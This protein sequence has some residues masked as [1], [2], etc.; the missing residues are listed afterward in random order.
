M[1][2]NTVFYV[3]LP[4]LTETLNSSYNLVKQRIE[5]NP[6]LSA[7]MNKQQAKEDRPFGF[8]DKAFARL[9]E[10]GSHLGEEITM[11][12]ELNPQGSPEEPLFVADLRNADGLRA[13]ID[14]LGNAPVQIVDDPATA[15]AGPGRDLYLWLNG[16]LLAASPKLENL[17]KF[18]VSLK[19]ESSFKSTSF[20]ARI[21]DRYR[22]GTSVIVAGDLE[23][24]TPNIA[25]KDKKAN[26]ASEQLGFTNFKHLIA[27]IKDGSGKAQNSAELTFSEANKGIAAWLAQ[28]A[29]M[30]SLNYISADANVIGAVVIKDPTAMADNLINAL[31]SVEPKFG[32]E[33]A[34]FEA[35]HGLSIRNDIAAP[36]GGEFAF[37][38]DGPLVPIPS[39]KIVVEVYDQARMQQTFERIV[40]EL[41]RLSQQ[42][43]KKGFT[44]DKSEESGQ[45][46]YTIK[47][48]DFPVEVNYAFSSGYVV[49]APSKALITRALQYRNS[50]NTIMRS[51]RFIASLPEDKQA[52]FSAMFY[53]NLAPVVNPIARSLGNINGKMR[54]GEIGAIASLA[55]DAPSLAYAYSY[56]DR[57]TLSVNT[58][59][60]ALNIGDLLSVPGSFAMQG[61]LKGAMKQ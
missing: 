59:K 13:A 21:A 18:A 15:Q 52:N 46:F 42:A 34:K 24:I 10:F 19:S 12:F 54:G 11:S 60:G 38:L 28:P 26:V 3:A 43:G 29:P 22:E 55:N 61:V 33:M 8:A 31:K 6:E 56:G 44:H 48:L 47:S 17:Q 20:Y 37:A 53:Q 39:W 35:E 51:P 5:Q 23:K 58:E 16:N 25:G 49:L 27:E 14:Q 7:W 45:M 36:L 1:P 40:G 9:R 50:G 57:I 2:A 30:G 32:E 41:N 4:N